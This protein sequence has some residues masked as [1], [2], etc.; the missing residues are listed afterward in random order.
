[1]AYN[2]ISPEAIKES[3]LNVTADRVAPDSFDAT[4]LN[5]YCQNSAARLG[6]EASIKGMGK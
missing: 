6:G 5:T 4:K 3:L 2:D 1:M